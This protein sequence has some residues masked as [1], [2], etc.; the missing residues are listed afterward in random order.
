LKIKIDEER[1]VEESA[2]KGD[3]KKDENINLRILSFCREK[4]VA[5]VLA[6]IFS[7]IIGTLYPVFSVFAGKLNN[8][9]FK[10]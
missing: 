4:K 8:A 6:F 3:N 9:M 7:I 2:S 1:E 10:L 5:L